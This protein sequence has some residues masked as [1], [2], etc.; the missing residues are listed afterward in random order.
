LLPRCHEWLV[1]HRPEQNERKIWGVIAL[2]GVMMAVQIGGGS[3]FGSLAMV[4]DGTGK[5]RDAAFYRETLSRFK[6]LSHVTVDVT[7]A[8][9]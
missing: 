3:L 4:A 9:A 6:A 8:A 5:P 7:R 2:C 1:W